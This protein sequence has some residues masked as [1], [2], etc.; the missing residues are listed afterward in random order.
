MSSC[1]P[2]KLFLVSNPKPIEELHA[3]P[4]RAVLSALMIAPER[5]PSVRAKL[6]PEDFAHPSHAMIYQAILH[7][8]A[9]GKPVDY[10]TVAARLNELGQIPLIGD[11]VSLSGVTYLTNIIDATPASANVSAHADLVIE[12]SQVRRAAEA[13][14][15]ALAKVKENPDNAK[16]ILRD[17][18]ERVGGTEDKDPFA[19]LIMRGEDYPEIEKPLDW[20]ARPMQLGPGRALLFVGGGGVGKTNVVQT[21]ALG[22][23]NGIEVLGGLVPEGPRRRVLHIDAD[24]GIRATRRRY[25]RLATGLHVDTHPDLLSLEDVKQK[26]PSFDVADPA[27]W[28]PLFKRYDLVIFD[29]LSGLVM[30]RAGAKEND[31]ETRAILDAI[32]HAST[33]TGCAALV[34]AHTGKAARDSS[35]KEHEQTSARGASSIE[36]ASGAKWSCLGGSKRGT[37]RKAKRLRDAADDDGDEDLVSEFTYVIESTNDFVPNMF[38]REGSPVRGVRVV[39]MFDASDESVAPRKRPKRSSDAEICEA[40]L[41]AVHEGEYESKTAV[42]ES[43]KSRGII[44]DDK[45]KRRICEELFKSEAIKQNALNRRLFLTPK[46]LA[47]LGVGPSNDQ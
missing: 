10:M 27:T 6:G 35:G 47:G 20:L 43:L 12:R 18:L 31:T 42:I 36:Q 38:T 15:L 39:V 41:R 25:R 44:G 45:V 26:N 16:E 34:I 13:A 28:T 2:N 5:L 33:S 11:G 32:R 14:A 21:A 24:Q 19:S 4:E 7:V 37:P 40:V 17:V 8:A 29:A 23:S 9:S 46:G 30:M 3:E 1:K 22:L